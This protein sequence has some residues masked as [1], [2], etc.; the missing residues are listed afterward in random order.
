ML[1][2]LA[3]SIAFVLSLGASVIQRNLEHKEDPRAGSLS[4]WRAAVFVAAGAIAIALPEGQIP[5]WVI[6][7]LLFSFWFLQQLI[8][9]V[10][11]LS[12]AS[13]LLVS[14]SDGLISTW[15]RL[16]SEIGRAHV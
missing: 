13:E 11:G 7:V 3:V 2:L 4:I 5:S 1:S 10:V 14:K 9:R 16:V 12:K 6:A 15:A 8:G